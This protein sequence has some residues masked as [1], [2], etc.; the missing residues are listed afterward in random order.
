VLAVYEQS[1]SAQIVPQSVDPTQ[2]AFQD[3]ANP[4]KVAANLW[5]EG[6]ATK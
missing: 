6:Q 5:F 4:G 3:P 1:E 2:T